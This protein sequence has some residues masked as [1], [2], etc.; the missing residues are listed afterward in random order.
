[1]EKKAE[2][3]KRMKQ[4]LKVVVVPEL[5]KM[6]FSGSF[7]HLRRIGEKNVDLLTFQFGLRSTPAFVVIAGSAPNKG[8]INHL[9]EITPAEK[10]TAWE[11]AKSKRLG[12]THGE[13]PWF[14]YAID[15]NPELELDLEKMNYYFDLNS[16]PIKNREFAI[17]EAK[18]TIHENK[19]ILEKGESI[20]KY[21]AKQILSLL[22]EAEAFWKSCN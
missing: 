8:I 22:T 1:M 12:S 17:A 13:D 10:L 6:G 11:T 15:G 4:A 5:R 16:T 7:P 20:Y 3:T 2:K 14:Y 9:N 21:R 19:L 18:R